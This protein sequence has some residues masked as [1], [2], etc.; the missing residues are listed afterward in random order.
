M[1]FYPVAFLG[2]IFR[3]IAGARFNVLLQNYLNWFVDG[4]QHGADVIHDS[5]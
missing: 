1:G 3:R 4:S 5:V 2:Y